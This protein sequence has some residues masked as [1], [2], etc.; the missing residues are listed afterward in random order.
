[1]YTQIQLDK[2][3]N[4]KFGMRAFYLI[5]DTLKIKMSQ[6]D[7]ENIGMKELAVIIWAGLFH[8]DKELTIDKTIDLIDEHTNLIELMNVMQEAMSKS[9]NLDNTASKGQGESEKNK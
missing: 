1:M 3:R 8:E 6:I 9:F 7:Y 4:L 5:E 2:T